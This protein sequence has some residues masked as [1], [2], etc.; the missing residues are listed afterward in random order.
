MRSV[1]LR[2][3]YRWGN[4]CLQSSTKFPKGPLAG[5]K[6]KTKLISA[7][8]PPLGHIICNSLPSLSAL[9]LKERL[10]F[11]PRSKSKLFPQEIIQA[12]N[13][14]RLKRLRVSAANGKAGNIWRHPEPR[15]RVAMAPPPPL[16]P[17]PEPLTVP[18]CGQKDACYLSKEPF[19]L[20]KEILHPTLLLGS[21]WKRLSKTE[22]EENWFLVRRHFWEWKKH[23]TNI[24]EMYRLTQRLLSFL[25]FLKFS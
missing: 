7:L 3:S 2:P 6:F 13:V 10:I 14:D 20:L 22:A 19:S 24:Q 5:M 4:Q 12:E 11:K 8:L 9:W 23:A 25:G 17:P 16:H 21:K 15:G 1:P 18:L